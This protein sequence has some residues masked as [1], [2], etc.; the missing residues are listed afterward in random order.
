MITP[1]SCRGAAINVGDI[2]LAQ[3]ER[4]IGSLPSIDLARPKSVTLGVRSGGVKRMLSGFRSRWT[5]PC[6]W[7]CSMR[8]GNLAGDAKGVGERQRTRARSCAFDQL[9]HERLTARRPRAP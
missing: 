7:A 3:V 1:A 6:S 8:V 5:M 9:H 2:E 4:R